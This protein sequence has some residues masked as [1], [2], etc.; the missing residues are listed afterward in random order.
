[1]AIDLRQFYQTFFD[2]SLDS[3]ALMETELLQ[4]EE[5]ISDNQG[6]VINHPDTES[7]NTI[8]R[9][10]HSIKGGSS[11]FG[12]TALSEFSHVL[13]SLLDDIREQRLLINKSTFSLMLQ[14]VDC[15]R[16]L[17]ENVRSNSP[18][19]VD[20]LNNIRQELEKIQ[21]TD[22]SKNT[23]QASVHDKH[24][25]N[26]QTADGWHIEFRPHENLFRSGNDPVKILREISALGVAHIKCSDSSLPDFDELDPEKCYLGWSVDLIGQVSK[27]AI[28]EVFD[29]VID[30][31]DLNIRTLNRAREA[32]KQREEKSIRV[33][34]PKVD[35]LVDLV[36]EL[37][38][39][40]T[41]LNQIA[42]NFTIDSIPKLQSSLAQL[43]RNIRDLQESILSVRMLPIAYAFNRLPRMVRDVSEHVGKKIELVIGRE[44]TELDK[45]VIDRITDPLMHIVRNCIDHG[46]ETPEERRSSGKSETGRI[47]IDS[48]QK[49]GDVII[50][51][52]DD[53]GGLQTEKI[54]EKAKKNG[55][56]EDNKILSEEEITELIFL[57]GFS[58]VSIVSDI[59]GRGVGMDVARNNIRSLGGSI[60]VQS[61]QGTGTMFHI[62]LPLTLAIVDGLSVSVGSQ[63]YIMPLTSIIESVHINEE[64]VSRPAGGPELFTLRKEYIPLVRLNELFNIS[65]SKND[66][67]QGILVIVEADGR[68]T[69]LFVDD[70]LGQQQVVIKSLDGNLGKVDGISSATVLGDGT[71]A[72]ILDIAELV[73]RANTGIDYK[74]DTNIHSL[75]MAASKKANNHLRG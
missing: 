24:S 70:L 59:S 54:I 8:F 45:T 67:T 29:W 5:V 4:I 13:E 3:L 23:K 63:V 14:S 38:I 11:T 75:T 37:V 72:L 26:A 27:K 10:I 42:G 32:S 48:F 18:L 53:G 58:T 56:I 12:F 6:D 41:M 39:T 65:D 46:I 66:L 55:L 19:D 60:N 35:A 1:M 33:S 44:Q 25:E 30:E 22:A 64:L 20:R 74:R 73:Q 34:T 7:L 52:M 47:K 40:Q 17:I 21:H 71:V 50:E 57:P 9:V 31:C 15:I 28:M 16:N 51:I 36:G 68:K 43:D 49:G 61:K 2:E 69:G 62:R